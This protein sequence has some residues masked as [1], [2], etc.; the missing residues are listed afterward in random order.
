VGE[1]RDPVAHGA[2]VVLTTVD[3]RC[4]IADNRCKNPGQNVDDVGVQTRHRLMHIGSAQA[5]IFL[6]KLIPLLKHDDLSR[7]SHSLDSEGCVLRR[8]RSRELQI[9]HIGT[10]RRC[11]LCTNQK[12][13]RV[14]SA[15]R[16]R[17]GRRRSVRWSRFGSDGL[18]QRAMKRAC[19]I[20][21]SR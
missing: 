18:A 20:D 16:V 15:Q 4:A 5:A 19:P 11:R 12:A 17:R 10:E 14:R 9:L 8:F 1:R 3:C 7:E 2:H 13:A 6:R 21:T